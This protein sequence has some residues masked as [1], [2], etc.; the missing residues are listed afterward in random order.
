MLVERAVDG[1]L[2]LNTPADQ[3]D[4]PVPVVAISAHSE[5]QNVTNIVLD[6]HKAVESHSVIYTNSAIAA[7]HSCVDRRPF[8]TRTIAGRAFSRSPAKS[9]SPSTPHLSSASILRAGL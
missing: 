6:H 2:L 4:V 1:F 8:P 9:A 3:I 7:L 5:V